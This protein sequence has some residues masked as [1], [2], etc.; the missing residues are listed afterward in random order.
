MLRFCCRVVR[1]GRDRLSWKLFENL[2]KLKRGVLDGSLKS[3]NVG[4]TFNNVVF[5]QCP[6]CPKWQNCH[7]LTRNLTE[8]C[9]R[10]QS[11]PACVVSKMRLQGVQNGDWQLKM[12]N[13]VVHKTLKRAQNENQQSADNCAGR[14]YPRTAMSFFIKFMVKKWFCTRVSKMRWTGVQNVYPSCSTTLQS[15]GVRRWRRKKQWG[16]WVL[17]EKAVQNVYVVVQNGL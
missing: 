12:K 3:L 15:V 10:G 4:Q 8:H 6:E 7:L 11:S 14:N 17:W 2:K 13:I 9:T 16:L 5:K 1:P